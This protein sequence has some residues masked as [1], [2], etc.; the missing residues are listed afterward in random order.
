MVIAAISVLNANILNGAK[1]LKKRKAV[2]SR[3]R[4][5]KKIKSSTQKIYQKLGS[6]K[7]VLVGKYPRRMDVR[8]GVI[9]LSR[10]TLVFWLTMNRFGFKIEF[11][12][13]LPN[14]FLDHG[15]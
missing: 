9:F 1:F 2:G 3:E 14:K 7:R 11:T 5:K 4:R 8:I 12:P 6:Q 15:R 10:Y 13:G